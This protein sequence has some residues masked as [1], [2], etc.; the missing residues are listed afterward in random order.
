MK[1]AIAAATIGGAA[2]VIMKSAVQIANYK[3]NSGQDTM[4]AIVTLLVGVS[5][6]NYSLNKIKYE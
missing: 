4:M 5:A 3:K 1:K 6:I 2:L